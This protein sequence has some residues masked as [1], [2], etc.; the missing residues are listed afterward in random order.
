MYISPRNCTAE[1]KLQINC[2]AEEKVENVG[3][4]YD[5]SKHLTCFLRKDANTYRIPIHRLQ[6]TFFS[7]E[8]WEY[9][10]IFVC[11]GC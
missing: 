1:D 5:N 11:E 9:N 10:R 2:T 3:L 6:I 4:E 7:E 8:E